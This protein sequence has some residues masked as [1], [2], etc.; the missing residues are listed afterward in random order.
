MP[1]FV[2]NATGRPKKNGCGEAIVPT[3]PVKEFRRG[4]AKKLA[5]V[6]EQRRRDSR[7]YARVAVVR[8]M[9][10]PNLSDLPTRKKNPSP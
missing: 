1:S 2:A 6:V 8:L 5:T 3:T 9:L 10:Q 7:S 4:S